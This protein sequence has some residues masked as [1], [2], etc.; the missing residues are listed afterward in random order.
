MASYRDS[1][2]PTQQRQPAQAGTQRARLLVHWDGGFI[3]RD[4]PSEGQ[5][6]FGRAKDC[7]VSIDDASV[8][9]RH[10]R[11]TLG[12]VWTV[13][14]LGSSN[15]T[16]VAGTTLRPNVPVPIRSGDPLEIGSVRVLFDAPAA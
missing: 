5:L 10:A 4:L 3:S 12:P 16:R 9:R 13:E 8:S 15:G 7:E 1:D 14:D 11:L 2:D 6:V